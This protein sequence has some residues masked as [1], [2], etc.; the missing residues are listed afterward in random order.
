M[1]E[2]HPS[3]HQEIGTKATD[4]TET[5]INGRVRRCTPAS[6]SFLRLPSLIL[7]LVLSLVHPH[8]SFFCCAPLSHS[9]D[10]RV[11]E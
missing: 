1:D 7:A 4:A 11:D 5:R 2:R 10:L 8:C 9:S 3:E 6:A